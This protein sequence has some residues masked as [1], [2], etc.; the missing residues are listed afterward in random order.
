MARLRQ[1]RGT[2]CSA[3]VAGFQAS[4]EA[5]PAGHSSPPLSSLPSPPQHGQQCQPR[6]AARAGTG[7]ELLLLSIFC[8]FAFLWQQAK[9]SPLAKFITIIKCS[10]LQQAKCG[11]AR[12]RRKK[13]KFAIKLQDF[14]SPGFR[15]Q[16]RQLNRVHRS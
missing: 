13:A 2:G 5:W 11:M 4:C 12:R 16:V 9:G 3:G 10:Q 15:K 8:L 6:H 1:E 7:R 14:V